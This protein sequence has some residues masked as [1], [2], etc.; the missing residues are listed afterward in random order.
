MV[1]GCIVLAAYLFVGMLCVR[2][3]LHDK[4]PLL[5]VWLGLA[6]GLLLFFW[7][8]VL[9]AFLVR[10]TLLAEGIALL[11]LAAL[12]LGALWWGRRHPHAP[13]RME[14]GDFRMLKAILLFALPLTVLSAYLQHTHTLRDVEGALHVGQSTYGDLPMHLSIALGLRGAELPTEYIIL[15]G[16]PLGYPILADASA[17]SLILFG[18]PVRWAMILPSTL[19]C[20]IVYMGYLL[21]AREMTGKVSAAVVAAALL[22]FNGGLGFLYDF[23]LAGHDFSKIIEIFTGYYKTPANQPEFNLR[24]SN[25]IVDFFVP[26]RT[27]LAGWALLLPALYFAR[28]A[29]FTRA[30]RMFLWAALFGAALPLVNTHAFMTLAL[31]SGAAFLYQVIARRDARRQLLIGTGLYLGIVVALALPQMIAFTFRQV[32]N[33]GFI[34]LHFNWLNNDGGRLTDLYPWFWIK[35]VGLPL[36]AMLFALLDFRRRDRMDLLGAMLIFIA[37]ELVQFQPNL[38][39]NN[40]LYYV[41]FL[42]MLPAAANWC[43]SLHRRLRGRRSRAVLAA[44]FLAG[45]TLSGALSIGR[46]VITDFQLFSA[47][48]A[49]AGAYIDEH[50]D[51]GAMFLT[52]LQHNNPVFA[53]AGRRVVCGPGLFLYYHGLDY[54]ERE[55]QVQRFYQSPRENLDLLAEYGVDY[56]VLDWSVRSE[57]YPDEAALDA[58][59]DV[60]YDKDGYRIYAT[61]G[62]ESP[63]GAPVD[64]P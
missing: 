9:A 54:Q 8:P 17:T 64:N 35:N 31:Y 37:A 32:G 4:S 16:A 62:A 53:L 58:L 11:A 25:L 34:R 5:R 48:E 50:T 10:F 7:L 33:E 51:P 28:E 18:M 43:L 24:W 12:L 22:F 2:V 30:R 13:R 56:I 38:Y 60:V 44:L 26:Q 19:M 55:R 52:G 1:I 47:A 42:L 45:S 29:F 39:D 6:L 63:S 59:F 61:G 21:L 3:F 49:R 41:W 27:F 57:L 20:G 40:K 14:A 36:F 23:D 15:P 46:E